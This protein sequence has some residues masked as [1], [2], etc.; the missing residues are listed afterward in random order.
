MIGKGINQIL[1]ESLNPDLDQCLR[2][3]ICFRIHDPVCGTDGN[4]YSN[5]C[6]LRC[7]ACEKGSYLE[8]EY[9]GKCKKQ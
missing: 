6:Q 9:R 8:V 3:C 5:S 4:T 1:E 2:A 7:S